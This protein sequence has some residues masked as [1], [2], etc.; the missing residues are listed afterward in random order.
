M[1][2][3]S[4]GAARNAAFLPRV[5]VC[6]NPVEAGVPPGRLS[7][8]RKLADVSVPVSGH[9]VKACVMGR[10]CAIVHRTRHSDFSV[11]KA[12]PG[13]ICPSAI[14]RPAKPFL[15]WR[16]MARKQHRREPFRVLACGAESGGARS[17]EGDLGTL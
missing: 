10:S 2:N 8:A 4:C 12:G 15:T 13:R 17:L 7:Q 6:G 11:R 9:T 14:R 5:P 3:A 1:V 16:F